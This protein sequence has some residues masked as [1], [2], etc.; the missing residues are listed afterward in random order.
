MTKYELLLTNEGFLKAIENNGIKPHHYRFI[1][2]YEDYK[3]MS[4]NGDKVTYIVTMLSSSYGI[5][6]RAVYRIIE[7]FESTA[8]L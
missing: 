4:L 2:L 6:E 5:S 8:I 1:Q 3:R 7:L